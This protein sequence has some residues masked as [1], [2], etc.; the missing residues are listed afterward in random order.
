MPPASPP[1]DFGAGSALTVAPIQAMIKD[2]GFQTTFLYFGLGQG[3]IIVIL[4]FFLFAPKA[5]QVPAVTQNANMH[6]D[7]GA[8]ISRPR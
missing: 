6:P 4:A 5:G 2:S 1:P 8:I 3:I 7:A